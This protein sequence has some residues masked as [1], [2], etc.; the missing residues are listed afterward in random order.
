MFINKLHSNLIKKFVRVC[1]KIYL[2]GNVLAKL[3]V[4]KCISL[5]LFSYLYY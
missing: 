5:F 1:K 2:T 4:K 3:V